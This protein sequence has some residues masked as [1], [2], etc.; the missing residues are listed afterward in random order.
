MA[1]TRARWEVVYD[2]L[3]AQIDQGKLA[4]GDRIPAELDLAEQFGFS[5][6]TV[7]TAITRLEQDGLVTAGAGSLGRQ[8]RRRELLSWNLTR[9][10]LGA[11]ADDPVNL[12]DQWEADAQSEGWTTRQVVHSVVELAA[13]AQVAQYLDCPVGTRLVRRRR[14]RYVSRGPVHDRLAMIADTWTPVKIARK[15]IKGVAPLMQEENVV[16]PGGIYRALGFNQVRYE[17]ELQVRMPSPDEADLLRM[18]PG[19]PV[20][21]H[22]RVG[23]DEEGQRVRVLISTAAGDLVQMRYTLDVPATR[24]ESEI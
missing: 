5:R 4:P 13:P 21:Q 2:D 6:A 7:R 18:E 16:Y 3:R 10:E 17:D 20:S 19:T 15:K 9:F 11:Y 1:G 22:A 23:I 8:V 24:P 14:L 12:V